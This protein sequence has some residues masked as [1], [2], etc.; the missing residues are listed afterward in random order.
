MSWNS[1]KNKGAASSPVAKA[2]AK[3]SASGGGKPKR[4]NV[5]DIRMVET[6][7]GPKAKVQ[8][9]KDVEVFYRGEKLDLGQYNSGFLKTK[10]E[11]LSDLDF[12]VE[13]EYITEDQAQQRADMIDEKNITSVLSIGS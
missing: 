12:L 6:K 13:K 4:V 3:P 7:N 8:F 10:E 2:T 9:A 1:Q 5:L 11:L